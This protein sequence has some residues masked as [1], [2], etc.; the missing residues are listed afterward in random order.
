MISA[1]QLTSALRGSTPPS[2]VKSVIDY[3]RAL[4]CIFDATKEGYNEQEKIN[5]NKTTAHSPR[6]PMVSPPPRV[7]IDKNF[8]NIVPVDDSDSDKEVDKNESD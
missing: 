1:K 8:P 6:G 5:C 2:I 7:A 3:L 4:T